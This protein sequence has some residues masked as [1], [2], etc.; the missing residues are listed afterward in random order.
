M[1]EEALPLIFLLTLAPGALFIARMKNFRLRGANTRT[2]TH[3]ST[4]T[5][6]R[7]CCSE[8][9]TLSP[10]H[11]SRCERLN[12]EVFPTYRETLLS[13]LRCGFFRVGH[14]ESLIPVSTTSSSPL[15]RQVICFQP[16]GRIRS[17]CVKT[18][19]IYRSMTYYN[20]T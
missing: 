5:L 18:I 8:L 16:H 15:S 19:A 9:W 10:E 4:H 12:Y 2:H 6:R 11:Y 20:M 1:S 3:T 13:I 14:H 17:R 7:N